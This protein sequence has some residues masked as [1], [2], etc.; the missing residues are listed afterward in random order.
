MP[1]ASN[2][3]SGPPPPPPPPPPTPKPLVPPLFSPPPNSRLLIPP[4]FGLP[5]CHSDAQPEPSCVGWQGARWGAALR[6]PDE[7]HR[8]AAPFCRYNAGALCGL[9][10]PQLGPTTSTATAT[11]TPYCAAEKTTHT[12]SEY[13]LGGGGGGGNINT[14]LQSNFHVYEESLVKAA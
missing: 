9:I 14:P 11:Q 2:S 10:E 6:T 7:G 4:S 13:C 3:V 5:C 8:R 1:V 12:H